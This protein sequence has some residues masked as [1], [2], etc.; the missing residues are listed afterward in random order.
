MN[1]CRRL[2]PHLGLSCALL[3]SPIWAADLPGVAITRTEQQNIALRRQ[4]VLDAALSNP[5]A[6]QSNSKVTMYEILASTA[7]SGCGDAA[8]RKYVVDLPQINLSPG[9]PIE[10]LPVWALPP[11]ARYLHQF[12]SCLTTADKAAIEAGLTRVKRGLFYHGTLNLAIVQMSSWYLFAQ[13][14][15]Q[16][17]WTDV[18]GRRYSSPELMSK[19]KNLLARRTYN[20]YAYGHYEM[21]S[22]T[23]AMTNVFPLNNLYDF[24]TDP[25]VKKNAAA[26]LILEVGVLRAHSFNGVTLSPLTRYITDQQNAPQPSKT[27]KIASSQQVLWYYYGAP[28]LA[29]YDFRALEPF[30]AIMLALSSWLPPIAQQSTVVATSD[31]F[32]TKIVTPRSNIIDSP[33]EPEI[34]GDALFTAK[35]AIGTANGGFQPAAYNAGKQLF[36][37]LYATASPFNEITC[38]HSYWSSNQ[39]SDAWMDRW[40]PFLQTY[41]YDGTSAVMLISIPPFDPWQ[42]PGNSYYNARSLRATN[43]DRLVQCRVPSDAEKIET[44][45][46]GMFIKNGDIYIAIRPLNATPT[47]S[48][49]A[50]PEA[51]RNYHVIKINAAAAALFFRVERDITGSGFDAFKAKVKQRTPLY[52]STSNSVEIV[53]ATGVKTTLSFN[54]ASRADGWVSSYPNI[55][56]SPTQSTTVT[57][58]VFDSPLLKLR[59]GTLTIPAG[60]QS[61]VYRPVVPGKQPSPPTSLSTT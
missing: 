10:G 49:G 40:S 5:L 39:G 24:A 48:N 18:D 13:Y 37:I 53:E 15:P 50:P 61:F 4:K 43:L 22:P 41:R 11:L 47:F 9:D 28:N 29:T 42:Y 44:S 36:S 12:G 45:A 14:F 46:E 27:Y 7:K 54:L 30:Y 51:T 32:V 58:A 6:L 17:T 52:K 57:T 38:S 26:E 60:T 23:Y 3:S 20:F 19:L 8:W 56:R 25:D 34:T 33:T 21:L 35:F 31:E 2:L 16:A 59:G 55:Q 1:T